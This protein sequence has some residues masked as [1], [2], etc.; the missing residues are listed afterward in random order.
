MKARIR[1]LL[2]GWC[3]ALLLP[4]TLRPQS[5]QEMT[6][7]S[8]AAPVPRRNAAA[9]YD[10]AGHRLII[11]GGRSTTGDRNDVWALH[12][13]TN[14]WTELTPATGPA[15][16]PRFTAN[17]VYDSAQQL[18]LIWS[19]QG[20]GFFNDV[21]AF[22]LR[23]YS[24]SQFN[25]PDPKPNVRYGTAAVFDPRRRE[26]VTFA[27]FT[28]QGRFDDTWRFKPAENAWQQLGLA[29]HPEKRCLHTACYDSRNHRMIIYGGQTNGP[30]GDIWA[31]DL[32]KDQWLD[33]TPATSPAGRWFAASIYDSRNHRVINFGGNLGASQ[34]NELWAFVLET[35][36][37]QQLHAAGVAPA[38][39]EGAAAIYLPDE[40]RMVIF[41]GR[42][43]ATDFNDVWFLNDLSAATS[44]EQ[45]GGTSTAPRSLRL[46]GN[47]PN[48]FN[49]ETVIVYE[50]PQPQAVT[51][52]I[53]NALGQ[54]TRRLLSQIVPA[55]QH[56]VHWDGKDE[57]GRKAAPGVYLCVLR[58][59]KF[60]AARKM[61]LLE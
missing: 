33:L 23:S 39:R 51:L 40:D 35:G 61:V 30:R 5:W 27:G 43:G 9:V 8:G 55:G 60:S 13:T 44:V 34:T 36:R 59:G 29:I 41:G 37:W 2:C 19:G 38:S 20:A 53:Y 26:L 18:M 25:P 6:P 48:P 1:L 21:W 10:T 46:L 22:D 42:G 58:S 14:T 57:R 4:L 3:A 15:P 16:A 49:P 52:E 31:F 54:R 11:F 7:A 50:L 28:D 47:Y 56:R 17:G 24:W 32:N 45:D 12:L